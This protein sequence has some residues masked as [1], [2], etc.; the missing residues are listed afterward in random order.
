MGKT[1]SFLLYDGEKYQKK[2]ILK[3]NKKRTFPFIIMASRPG[4]LPTFGH[5]GG[6]ALG[7]AALGCP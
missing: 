6:L 7:S 1:M 4:R 2:P 5:H 3:K